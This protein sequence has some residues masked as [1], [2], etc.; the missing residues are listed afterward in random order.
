MPRTPSSAAAFSGVGALPEAA[1]VTLA[2][3]GL[4]GAS[5]SYPGRAP[6]RDRLVLRFRRHSPPTATR[7]SLARVPYPARGL[8]QRRRRPRPAAA[9][10]TTLA[11]SSTRVAGSGMAVGVLGMTVPS[12]ARAPIFGAD[13]SMPGACAGPSVWR[14]PGR[15]RITSPVPGRVIASGA[16]AAFGSGLPPA[17]LPLPSAATAPAPARP[18]PPATSAAL[19]TPPSPPAAPSPAP[20]ALPKPAEPAAPAAAAEPLPG[21]AGRAPGIR[22]HS[23]ATGGAGGPYTGA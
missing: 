3:R 19:A 5:R 12:G 11:A 21:P 10:I 18:S 7:A 22:A 2:P 16:K 1:F 20:A 13:G 9:A 14:V 17:G 15:G 6:R 8:D 23:A 4:R